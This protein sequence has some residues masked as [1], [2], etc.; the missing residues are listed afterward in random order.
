MQYFS[1]PHTYAYAY[2]IRCSLIKLNSPCLQKYFSPIYF[3]FLFFLLESWWLDLFTDK[4]RDKLPERQGHC[5]INSWESEAPQLHLKPSLPEGV[6]LAEGGFRG[7]GQIPGRRPTC[8]VC[9]EKG[10]IL[11]TAFSSDGSGYKASGLQL[12]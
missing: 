12:A 2:V 6:F 11:K 9:P 7:K 5:D 3:C 8:L 1:C 10:K 4:H